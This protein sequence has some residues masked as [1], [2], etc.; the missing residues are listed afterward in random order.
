MRYQYYKE[1]IK[2]SPNSGSFFKIF[3]LTLILIVVVVWVIMWNQA[4]T[5]EPELMSEQGFYEGYFTLNTRMDQTLT[6]RFPSLEFVEGRLSD[7]GMGTRV[8]EISDQKSIRASDIKKL[9]ESTLGGFGFQVQQTADADDH[10]EFQ[11]GSDSTVWSVYRFEYP[12]EKATP[13]SILPAD[14]AK[15]SKR[16]KL[17]VI[18]D[19][20]GY[21]MN[22][23]IT[24]FISLK[25]AFTAAVIPGRPYSTQV[26]ERLNNRSIQTLIHMPMVTV[27][28]STSEP[29]YALSEDLSDGEIVRRLKKA[30]KDV[31]RAIGM[32]NHQGSGGTQS[33]KVMT[34]VTGFLAEQKMFFID[35]RTIAASVGETVARERYVPTNS[36]DVFLDEVDDQEAIAGELFRLARIAK[37]QGEAIGIGHCRPN[38]LKTLKKYL[39]ALAEAGFDLV[40]VSKL[41]K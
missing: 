13:T 37:E 19:D 12:E 40:P 25:E 8:F 22:E 17:A 35:S 26:D 9:L 11:V 18:I 2:S 16:P 3:L 29:D 7:D 32:N 10:W 24:G 4:N 28:N 21:S 23:T 36:R 41:A 15:V 33:R 1:R 5:Y 31:P 38:T 27:T 30:R 20:F 6:R 34:G 39:P 14:I